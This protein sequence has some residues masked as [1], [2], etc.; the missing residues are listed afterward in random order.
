MTRRKEAI[1]TLGNPR[2]NAPWST[3]QLPLGAHDIKSTQS[4]ASGIPTRSDT[5]DWSF[6]AG[7]MAGDAEPDG[8]VLWTKHRG[9]GDLEVRL[10]RLGRDEQGNPRQDPVNNAT[11]IFPKNPTKDKLKPNSKFIHVE[12]RGLESGTDYKYRFLE[13]HG[14]GRT[15][16]SPIGYFRTAIK[17][18]TNQV[19][20]K[21]VAFGGTSCTSQVEPHLRNTNRNLEA[22]CQMRDKLNI[23]FF[24]HA[25]DQLYCDARTGP[26]PADISDYQRT[27]QDAFS[28]NRGRKSNSSPKG[29]HALH[30]NFGMYTTWDDHEVV[31]DWQ[32]TKR[33]PKK[34][35]KIAEDK[36]INIESISRSII[37][38]GK[39]SFFHHQPI[40]NKQTNNSHQAHTHRPSCKCLTGGNQLSERS[41]GN[42]KIWGS[43][44]W[45]NTLELFILDCRS[46]RRVVRRNNKIVRG[47]YISNGQMEWLINGLHNSPAIF[48][49]ILNSSPIGIFPNIQQKK[50]LRQTL[51]QKRRML[52]QKIG[53]SRRIKIFIK[54]HIKNFVNK[55]IELLSTMKLRPERDTAQASSQ[56]NTRRRLMKLLGMEDRRLRRQRQQQ[57]SSRAMKMLQEQAKLLRHQ[58]NTLRRQTKVPENAAKGGDYRWDAPWLRRQR[59]RILAAAQC[60]GGVCWL[61]GDLH[62]GSVGGLGLESDQ[63]PNVCEVLMG[64]GG[65]RVKGRKRRRHVRDFEKLWNMHW[66]FSTTKDNYVVIQA[67]PGPTNTE[68]KIE[69]RFFHRHIQIYGET[70]G[71]DMKF[72]KK[73]PPP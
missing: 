42:E 61:S 57:Q 50:L 3:L 23:S 8:V 48:K 56:Q 24:V 66:N 19:Q 67:I 53:T 18:L 4:S 40:C 51:N 12:I 52:K 46:E 26:P 62:Y 47:R 5:S 45:G 49:F 64:P 55:K 9:A 31:D 32:G 14:S 30:R 20:P 60:V 59:E 70:R 71:Y 7:I 16:L 10:W 22:A 73:I 65:Q 68:S 44:R 43:F 6:P 21:P 63:Y 54:R 15:V 2:I 34:I 25:G 27:Y 11:I 37:S 39:K 28:R 58:S 29:L 72:I 36:S 17:Y 33:F 38:A 35:R 13:R 1:S 69:I 41:R